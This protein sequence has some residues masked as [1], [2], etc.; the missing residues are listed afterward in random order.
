MNHELAEEIRQ[1]RDIPV[2][3]LNHLPGRSGLVKA[4][5]EPQA[6]L[7]QI[8]AELV[9]CRPTDVFRQ[10]GGEYRQ[11]LMSNRQDRKDEG[12]TNELR[13]LGSFD[14][15]IDE[16]SDDLRVDQLKSDPSEQ[17]HGQQDH[18]RPVGP[19]V[20]HQEI[21]ILSNRDHRSSS[22]LEDRWAMQAGREPAL[23][24]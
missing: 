15:L 10:V 20:V 22:H 19:Q 12:Q 5:V 24:N 11:S 9:G 8:P 17:E 16:G 14:C 3:S 18:S 23:L 6:V 13:A 2:D 4:H 7:G 1:G 21:P